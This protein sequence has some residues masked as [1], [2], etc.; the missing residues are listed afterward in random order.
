MYDYVKLYLNLDVSFLADLYSLWRLTF[1][2]L[3]SLD[4]LYFLMLSSYAFK[5][6]LYKTGMQLDTIAAPV[7]YQYINSIIPGGGGGGFCSVGQ[8]HG[9]CHFPS[10]IYIT[11]G[12]N[13]LE[14]L[15]NFLRKVLI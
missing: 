14:N 2:E 3:F 8:R 9:K 6:M 11:L 13:Y 7:L 10:K 1:L 4:C 15:S 5:A 12:I